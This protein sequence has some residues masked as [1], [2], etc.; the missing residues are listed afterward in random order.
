MRLPLLA[1]LLLAL[2]ACSRAPEPLAP[3][4]QAVRCP[5]N[6]TAHASGSFAEGRVMFLC[7]AKELAEK[8]HL[9]RCDLESHPMVCEDAGSLVF[10]R[11]KDGVVYT[12]FYPAGKRLLDPE[13]MAGGSRL[14]VNFRNGPPRQ[15]TFDEEETDWRFLYPEAGR[16]LPAGFEIVKGAVCDRR[17][18]TLSSGTCNLEARSHSLYWHIAVSYLDEPGVGITPDEYKAEMAFWLPFL[19]RLVTDPAPRK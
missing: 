9:L 6:K 14:T 2:A 15:A 10:S 8:P 13:T 12:S 1:L 17:T 3:E 11:G 18:T 16:L 7:I 5:A 4:L 19:G